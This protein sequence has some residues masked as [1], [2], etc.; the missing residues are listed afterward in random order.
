MKHTTT[1]LAVLSVLFLL[2]QIT[3]YSCNSL[4]VKENR[5]EEALMF[6]G[7]NRDELEKVLSHYHADSLKLQAAIFLI[8]N[9]PYYYTYKGKVLD[10]LYVVLMQVCDSGRYDKDRFSYLSPFPYSQLTKEYDS[11]IIK[12][13]YLI[14]NIDYSF[15]VWRERPWGE[16]ISFADFCEFI[17][18]YRIKNEPLTHWKRTFYDHY[19][20]I[21]DSLYNGTDVVEAC[22]ALNHYLISKQWNYFAEINDPH[23]PADFLIDKRVGDCRDVTDRAIYVMRSVGIPIARDSYFYSPARR[24]GHAWNALLDTTGLSVSFF[25]TDFDPERGKQVSYVIGKV[26]RHCYA[27]QQ[28][29]TLPLKKGFKIPSPLN[30]FF[31]KDVSSEYFPTAP[32]YVDCDYIKDSSERPVWL[33]IFS[34]RGW[35]PIG[36]GEYKDGRACFQHAAEADLFYATLYDDGTGNLRPA[37]PAFKID[38]ETGIVL[39]FRPSGDSTRLVLR[40]KYPLAKRQQDFLDCMRNGRFE[41]SNSAKFHQVDTLYTVKRM[42]EG[43]YYKIDIDNPKKY[44]YVRYISDSIHRGD[45]AE[46]AWYENQ[47]DGKPLQGKLLGTPPLESGTETAPANAFDEDLLTYFSSSIRPGWVGLDL[48]SPKTINRIVYMPRNDDNF[49]HIGDT[50]ELFYHTANGWKSLGQQIAESDELV[51]TNAPERALFWL[52]NLTRGR[53]EQIFS[54][55]GGKQHFNLNEVVY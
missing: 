11:R 1:T 6:A 19:T 7:D 25:D 54:Y 15:K 8:E 44:R 55:Y 23:L 2:L 3:F 38:P 40:R 41:A 16:Y 17:L 48:G 21:L 39:H 13:D 37:G 35:I 28:E 5:L 12:A 9:M 14:E 10:S 27:F 30:N 50:Y 26:Y 33:G 51:Y 18:P 22:T 53:E 46:L 20:P 43:K 32:F 49:I 34:T 45:I 42:P 4:P 47:K 24:N 31:L 29:R 36:E 52:R